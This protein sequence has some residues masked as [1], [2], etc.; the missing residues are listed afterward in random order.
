MLEH[1]RGEVLDTTGLDVVVN[2]LGTTGLATSQDA[3][4]DPAAT[5]P[6]TFEWQQAWSLDKLFLYFEFAVPDSTALLTVRVDTAR[7]RLD[8][9]RW[10]RISERGR[11]RKPYKNTSATPE[12]SKRASRERHLRI[13]DR[14]AA[15]G[16]RSCLQI[17]AK[18][19]GGYEPC[20]S[21]KPTG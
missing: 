3:A 1:E 7:I 10:A 11:L 21:S 19:R 15:G 17:L 18:K 20:R 4:L 6:V 8:L 5:R 16:P 13:T 2:V 12:R 14:V 9:R